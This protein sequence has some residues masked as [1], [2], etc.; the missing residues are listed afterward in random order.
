SLPHPEERVGAA[1]DLSPSGEARGGPHLCG[2][3]DLCPC[4]DPPAPAGPLRPGSDTPRRAGKIGHDSDA[5]CVPAHYRRTLAGHAALYPT[6]ARADAPALS[7]P[8]VIAVATAAAH[9]AGGDRPQP[10]GA[11]ENVV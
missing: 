3:P 9:Q 4:G 1:S 10:P 5:R 7:T 6:G 11:A 2:F 8:P